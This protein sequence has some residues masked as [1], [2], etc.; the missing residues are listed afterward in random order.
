MSIAT[1]RGDGGMTDLMFGRRISKT[2]ARVEA[3]GTLDELNAA[4]GLSRVW[5]GNPLVRE[6]I[7]RFQEDLVML[8]GEL[9]TLEEDRQR[10]LEKGRSVVTRADVERLDE[11]V[12]KLEEGEGIQFSH[13]AMPG[14]AGK[15]GA[16]CL[17]LARTVAR[18][19]ERE[20]ARLL[21]QQVIQNG[22]VIRYLNRLSDLIWLLARF[23]ERE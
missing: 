9:A 8:M 7:V 23:E 18:R 22:E 2:D 6:Q 15:P 21:E 12:R 13:W 14:A 4:L 10:Y 19:G 5:V 1:K 20:V 16:A 11:A 17:D 3:Y